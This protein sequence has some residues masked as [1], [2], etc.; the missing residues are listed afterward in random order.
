MIY[1]VDSLQ[2]NTWIIGSPTRTQRQ[3]NPDCLAESS[4]CTSKLDCMLSAQLL[5]WLQLAMSH[6]SQSS[7]CC[8]KKSST[9]CRHAVTSAQKGHDS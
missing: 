7:L 4:S 9:S 6:I 3:A 2:T 5:A 8:L 1:W